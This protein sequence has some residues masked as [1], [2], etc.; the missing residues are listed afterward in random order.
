[1]ASSHHFH[2]HQIK[3]FYDPHPGFVGAAFAL[4]MEVA[5]V[6]QKLNGKNIPVS[7]AVNII[8][9]AAIAS[10]NTRVNVDTEKRCITLE[11]DCNGHY[12]LA[13]TFCVI[14]FR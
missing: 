5:E 10:G 2:I 14:K 9:A 13:H 3:E 11:V 6:A 1:M 4:P 8:L 7:K 12:D